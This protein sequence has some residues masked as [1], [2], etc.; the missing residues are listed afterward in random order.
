MAVDYNQ[1]VRQYGQSLDTSGI[2]KGIDTFMK[3]RKEAIVHKATELSNKTYSAMVKPWEETIAGDISDASGSTE[4]WALKASNLIN[5]TSGQALKAYQDAAKLKGDK[6]YNQLLSSGAFDPKTFKENY[7]ANIATYMPQI[8]RKL[9]S[10]KKSK[11]LNDKQMKKFLDDNNLTHLVQKYGSDEGMLRELTYPDR[12][13][14]QWYEQKGKA[15]GLTGTATQVGLRGA[16]GTYAAKKLYEIGK[17]NPLTAKGKLTTRQSDKLDDILRKSPLTE[18]AEGAFEKKSQKILDKANNEYSKGFEDYKKTSKSK[19][20]TTKGFNKTKAG[21]KLNKTVNTAS[22]GLKAG[23]DAGFRSVRN[24]ADRVIKKHGK[25]KALRLLMGKLGPR[26]ALSIGGKLGLGMIPAG[27]TQ[28]AAGA[29]LAYDVAN[30]YNI[31][32]ELAE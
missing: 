18:K 23:K 17:Q 10:Y 11:F 6:V 3:N 14:K 27:F 13:W 4:A 16:T 32:K 12:T 19:N 9:E 8:E 26:A 7:D 29:L 22:K 24:M 28:V 5:M 31:L 1:Y 2:Q 30:M 20:P 25:A 21:A 15:L